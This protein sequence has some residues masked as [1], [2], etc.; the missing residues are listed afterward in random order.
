MVNCKSLKL[1]MMLGLL[2]IFTSSLS[3]VDVYGNIDS[4]RGKIRD[5]ELGDVSWDAGSYTAIYEKNEEGIFEYTGLKKPLSITRLVFN[6]NETMDI[7]QVIVKHHTPLATSSLN[8]NVNKDLTWPDDPNSF[9]FL[10]S[11]LNWV[12]PDQD[13]G[14]TIY[15]HLRPGWYGT[16]KGERTTIND[17]KYEQIHHYPAFSGNVTVR[18]WVYAKYEV[19]AKATYYPTWA[20]SDTESVLF[21]SLS[22]F[23][24][25]KQQNHEWYL[26]GTHIS[27][28]GSWSF[29][30]PPVGHYD[31]LLKISNEYG[32]TDEHTLHLRVYPAN[33][34]EPD[35]ESTP[36]VRVEGRSVTFKSTSNLYDVQVKSYTWYLNDEQVGTGQSWTW[37]NP[38]RGDYKVKLEIKDTMKRVRSEEKD[39]FVGYDDYT[40]SHQIPFII[41]I[42][43][44][45]RTEFLGGE[46]ISITGTVTQEDVPASEVDIT[47]NIVNN[48]DIPISNS[49]VKTDDNGI[50]STIIHFPN[51][52]IQLDDEGKE[53]TYFIDINANDPDLGLSAY[54][55]LEVKTKSYLIKPVSLHLV[56]VIEQTDTVPLLAVD[57]RMGVRTYFE[58][59]WPN[60][61]PKDAYLELPVKLILSYGDFLEINPTTNN[62]KIVKTQVTRDGIKTTVGRGFADFLM[63]PKTG[64]NDIKIELDPERTVLHANM[65]DEVKDLLTLTRKATGKKMNPLDVKFVQYQDQFS[66]RRDPLDYV[67]DVSGKIRNYMKFFFNVFPTP[68][69]TFTNDKTVRP[70]PHATELI[71]TQRLK[72][73][74]MLSIL[75]LESAHENNKVVGIMPD[76]L[77]WFDSGPDAVDGVTY[78]VPIILNYPRAALVKYGSG[79]GVPAHELTHTYGIHKKEEYDW[80][81][82]PNSVTKMYYISGA[83]IEDN[84]GP[85]FK[86]GRIYDLSDPAEVISAFGKNDKGQNETIGGIFCYMGDNRQAVW[87]CEYTYNEIFRALMDPPNEPVLYIQG[88][89]YQ[90]STTLLYP[91]YEK[92]ALPDLIEPGNFTVRLV[93]REGEIISETSF[94]TAGFDNYFGFFVPSSPEVAFVEIVN[95]TDV[96]IREER[97]SAIPIISEVNAV[98]GQGN[99]SISWRSSDADSKVLTTDIL[100]SNDA[101]ETWQTLTIEASGSVYSIS[102]EYLPG[103][104]TCMVKLI[105][106]DGFNTVESVS[107]SFSIEEHNPVCVIVTPVDSEQYADELVFDGYGFDTD[108]GLIET[109]VEWKSDLD[110]YLGNGSL[111][112]ISNLSPGTHTVSMTVTDSD[113]NHAIKS[114]VFT[115]LSG[116]EA[117]PP[118][119]KGQGNPS[120]E[121]WAL[122]DS[123]TLAAIVLV[124]SLI[125]WQIVKYVRNRKKTSD[126]VTC[127]TCGKSASW[128]EEYKRWYCHDCEEYL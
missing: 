84:K 82:P 80:P 103:G 109:A 116:T 64:T 110:G 59:A 70:V 66:Y 61:T 73:I 105:V 68:E 41:T 15:I 22:K 76:T 67:K 123:I 18:T 55:R 57:K 21:E 10:Q 65:F 17:N 2:V 11:G 86:N 95:G 34:V 4:W 118:S 33:Y 92:T 114:V 87:V 20:T 46:K 104:E 69:L 43:T 81:D 37:A 6:V 12:I 98:N 13:V 32:N 3:F 14:D 42:D 60:T 48:R 102:S 47:V 78:L 94:G 30:N 93:S 45:G 121:P 52:L 117:D 16:T 39:V 36:E 8:F 83:P 51:E 122:T 1:A 53:T 58:C 111:L 89:I 77:D 24:A 49:E 96:L 108:D 35:F 40:P 97:T 113:N 128:I 31:I 126:Q 27:S 74:D 44:G 112:R 5:V 127:S 85:I 101:G 124:P 115:V 25:G 88:A 75:S 100:F 125:I 99:L 106:T 71:P 62:V 29:T 50:F 19:E 9:E 119:D 54:Q 56:Q 120:T 28:E 26:N 107:N 7:D 38:I 91:V 23:W 63:I 72:W 90:N 79:I